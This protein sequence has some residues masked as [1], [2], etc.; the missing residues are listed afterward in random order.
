MNGATAA[1]CTG[2]AASW[3]PIHGDCTCPRNDDGEIE[4]HYE[5]GLVAIGP[6]VAMSNTARSVVHYADDCPL[7]SEASNHAGAWHA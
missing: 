4:W 3:C 7:H 5:R 1:E 6:I 2:V